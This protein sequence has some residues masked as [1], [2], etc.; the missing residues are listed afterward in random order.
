M[1]KKVEEFLTEKKEN[2][3]E[4][5]TNIKSKTTE[6][7]EDNKNTAKRIA[8]GIGAA[9]IVTTSA[10][11]LTSCDELEGGLIHEFLEQHTETDTNNEVMT[12]EEG[13]VIINKDFT[14]DEC[15]EIF[16]KKFNQRYPD[17]VDENYIL[18]RVGLAF[19]KTENSQFC[20][21][22]IFFYNNNQDEKYIF[23]SRIPLNYDNYCTIRDAIPADALL[24]PEQDKMNF[25]STG[26]GA[27]LSY[28]GNGNLEGLATLDN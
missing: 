15:E 26:G 24:M 20:V 12:D 13:N 3:R 17:L 18:Q 6:F 9:A 11:G 16:Y 28:I 5:I 10:M 1:T 25:V 2:L 23:I 4:L 27:T 7:I 21:S 22:S 19:N 8:T 14:Y